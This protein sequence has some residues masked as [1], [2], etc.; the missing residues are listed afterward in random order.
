MDCWCQICDVCRKTINCG[1]EQFP[2]DNEIAECENCG[3]FVCNDC[4]VE[5]DGLINAFCRDCVGNDD[6][7]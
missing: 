5:D 7:Y 6:D 1:N 4:C 2:T 3:K